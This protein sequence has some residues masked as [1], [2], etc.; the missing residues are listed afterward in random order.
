MPYYV[1]DREDVLAT[2][3]GITLR[4]KPGIPVLVNDDRVGRLCLERG[5]R[6]VETPAAPA[7]VPVPPVTPAPEVK[8]QPEMVSAAT[9]EA[10]IVRPVRRRTIK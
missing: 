10:Q 5:Y 4:M 8:R 2:T 6:R 1:C 7:A 9:H 3:F